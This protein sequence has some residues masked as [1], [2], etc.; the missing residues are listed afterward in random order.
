METY[1]KVGGVRCVPTSSASDDGIESC[2]ELAGKVFHRCLS[3]LV[4]GMPTNSRPVNDNVTSTVFNDMHIIRR[5][6]YTFNSSMKGK[7]RNPTSCP[8]VVIVSSGTSALLHACASPSQSVAF[9]S[10]VG[11]ILR[12][13]FNAYSVA[14]K[15]PDVQVSGE[16]N[17]QVP[18]I[19][20]V[21][22]GYL[23]GFWVVLAVASTF[24][25][26][27]GEKSSAGTVRLAA[28]V[29]E[30]AKSSPRNV[31]DIVRRGLE[32]REGSQVQAARR[33]Y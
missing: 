24:W 26:I 28:E 23:G 31:F 20:S 19:L 29:A 14:G 4:L 6:T 16:K 27:R 30:T 8:T 5:E 22:W 2:S 15:N 18:L 10:S 11:H 21:H 9:S 13:S 3:R 33:G 12:R 17:C 32:E 25:A 7:L 1:R